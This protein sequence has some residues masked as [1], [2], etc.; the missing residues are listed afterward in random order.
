VAR[1]VH[2]VAGRAGGQVLRSRLRSALLSVARHPVRRRGWAAALIAR[3]LSRLKKGSG[4]ISG[5]SEREL[6]IKRNVT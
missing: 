6:L 4:Y 2:E 3:R 1:F 5:A